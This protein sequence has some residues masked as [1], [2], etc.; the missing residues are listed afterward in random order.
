MILQSAYSCVV[1]TAMH[2]MTLIRKHIIMWHNK[3]PEKYFICI[4]FH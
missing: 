1:Y 2:Y 4:L 3:L